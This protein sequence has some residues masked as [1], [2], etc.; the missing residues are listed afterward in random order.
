MIKPSLF[1]ALCLAA[2]SAHGQ[3]PVPAPGRD[4]IEIPSGR[5][6]D[7]S[8]GSVVVEE[9]FNYAC[10]ACFAFEPLFAAWTEKLPPYVKLEHVP[11]SFR[12]D[13]VQYARAY[14]AAVALGV[15]EETHQAVYDGIH[16]TRAL[17]GE[18]APPDEAR[19]ARFY[20]DHGVDAKE[21]LAAMQSVGVNAKVRRASEHMQRNRIPSTPSVVVN[22]RYL[23][24]G[25]SYADMLRIA[26]YLID[27]EHAGAR[28]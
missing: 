24:R 26:S 25:T 6:L 22:G 1:V 7:P 4:Y 2:L 28:Q 27:N 12:A 14:Y 23:V 18:G 9:F 10:P 3:S 15:A 16:R 21:F 13:F 5:P 11:A 19:I 20:A 8:D 17:P